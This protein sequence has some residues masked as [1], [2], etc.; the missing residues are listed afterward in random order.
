M[1]I[2]NRVNYVVVDELGIDPLRDTSFDAV[3]R[4]QSFKRV[5]VGAQHEFNPQLISYEHYG[6]VDFWWA[7]LYYNKLADNFALAVGTV[8]KVPN[9]NELTSELT[10]V[11]V[12]APRT[13]RI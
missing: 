4:V 9:L 1:A 12:P 7:I 2:G 8:I 6:V 13:Q 10:K 3:M 11:N 5:S